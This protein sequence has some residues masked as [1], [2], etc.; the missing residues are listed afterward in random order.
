MAANCFRSL[1]FD[2][3]F[4]YYICVSLGVLV[5]RH[6][7]FEDY[8]QVRNLPVLAGLADKPSTGIVGGVFK[9]MFDVAFSLAA[10]AVFSPLIISIAAFLKI[11]TGGP[12]LFSHQRIGADGKPF[13]CLKFRT[14][15]TDAD[16]R[17]KELLD[18]DP[19]AAAEFA[20]SYKLKNDPR[21]IPGVGPFLRKT[22]LDEL[23]QFFNVLFGQM[24]VVGPRPVTADEFHEFYGVG[25]VYSSARPGITGAW[26]TS[27]RNDVSFANRVRMDANYVHNWTMLQDIKIVL[28]TVKVVCVDRD[29]S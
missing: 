29:G 18:A 3:N 9:R 26:Q 14:M 25:H 16:V 8:E 13:G 12:V 17:L 11:R 10:I 28:R 2:L 4:R 20:E 5:M 7:N 23:P 24:S 21:I 22:S 1:P 15:V 27:G 19:D 6:G